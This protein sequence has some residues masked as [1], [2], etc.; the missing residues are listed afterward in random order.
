[1]GAVLSDLLLVARLDAGK[2]DLAENPST[3]SRFSRRRPSLSIRCGSRAEFIPRSSPYALIGLAYGKRAM[4]SG[5][6][7][8]GR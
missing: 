6:E 7:G 2:V 5:I 8:S 4:Q 1:M 3:W